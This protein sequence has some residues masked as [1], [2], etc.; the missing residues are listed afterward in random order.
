MIEV[1]R[2]VILTVT[3]TATVRI[4][5]YAVLSNPTVVEYFA[6][7]YGGKVYLFGY[8]HYA[9]GEKVL[10]RKVRTDGEIQQMYY[11]QSS[12]PLVGYYEFEKGKFFEGPNNIYYGGTIYITEKPYC[13]FTYTVPSGLKYNIYCKR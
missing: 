3:P 9:Y 7:E 12:R 10:F 1:S 4:P 5:I 6:G 13:T 2:S 8:V 11:A